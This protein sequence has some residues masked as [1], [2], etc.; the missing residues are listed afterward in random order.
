MTGVD[1]SR[2]LTHPHLLDWHFRIPFRKQLRPKAERSN[3]VNFILFRHKQADVRATS[4]TGLTA[5][6]CLGQAN[7]QSYRNKGC[8]KTNSNVVCGTPA[9]RESIDF[10]TPSTLDSKAYNE[11]SMCYDVGRRH[12]WTR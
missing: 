11:D 4:S 6:H 8:T 10:I 7:E 12:S 1:V 2:A 9:R 3:P 5:L